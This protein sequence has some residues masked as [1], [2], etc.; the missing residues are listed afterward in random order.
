MIWISVIMCYLSAGYHYVINKYKWMNA[1]FVGSFIWAS[2]LLVNAIG[3]FEWYKLSSE[4]ELY[5]FIGTLSFCIG[6][7]STGRTSSHVQRAEPVFI[8]MTKEEVPNAFFIIQTILI[9]LMIPMTIKAAGI[10][11]SSGYNMYMVRYL[12]SN[13]AESN[14]LMNTFQRIFY[15][16]YGVGP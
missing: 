12:Y 4:A 5:L 7:F 10:F 14:S 3:P 8:S 13:G 2:V 1:G 16:H 11:V 15:I 6:L 9:I